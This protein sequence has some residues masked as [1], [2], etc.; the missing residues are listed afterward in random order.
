M[1]TGRASSKSLRLK[2]KVK[3]DSLNEQHITCSYSSFITL[4]ASKNYVLI[5]FKQVEI[6]LLTSDNVASIC[7]C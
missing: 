3:G 7:N 5:F 6:P 1:F 2:F 4:M